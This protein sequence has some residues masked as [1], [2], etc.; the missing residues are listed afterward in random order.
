MFRA[1]LGKIQ[2]KLA[3]RLTGKLIIGKNVL[4]ENSYINIM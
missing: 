2:N 4:K 1:L 3:D